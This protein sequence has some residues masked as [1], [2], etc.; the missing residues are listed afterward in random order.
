MKF[1]GKEYTEVKDRLI[2]FADEFPQASMKTKLISV[3]QVIDTPTGETC[4]EYV[5]K[6]IVIPNPIQQP[7][8]YYM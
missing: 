1:K 7:E 5:V 6:A 8:W 4:N 3:S 2:A